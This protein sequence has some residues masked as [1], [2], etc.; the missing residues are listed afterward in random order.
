M[1][2]QIHNLLITL[3]SIGNAALIFKFLYD[4]LKKHWTFRSILVF[5]TIIYIRFWCHQHIYFLSKALSLV[6]QL[7]FSKQMFWSYFNNMI[8]LARTL[9]MLL[10]HSHWSCGLFEQQMF[11][12]ICF[13]LLR[14]FLSRACTYAICC[15]TTHLKLELVW[16]PAFLVGLPYHSN[17]PFIQFNTQ[18]PGV[19]VTRVFY[20]N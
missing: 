18:H 17:I 12:S 2:N 19:T 1:C 11:W 15:S 3:G 10:Y 5:F 9:F 6:K 20:S 8:F 4:V 13:D 16:L 14:I 7:C